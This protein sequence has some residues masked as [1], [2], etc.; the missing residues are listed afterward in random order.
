[1]HPDTKRFWGINV[2]I[3]LQFLP[4]PWIGTLP[5]EKLHVFSQL[6]AFNVYSCPSFGRNS[7]GNS[8]LSCYNSCCE[9]CG[10]K[11]WDS[12]Y[13]Q[14]K[15]RRLC[16]VFKFT[17]CCVRLISCLGQTYLWDWCE[18]GATALEKTECSRSSRDFSE[19][20]CRNHWLEWRLTAPQCASRR[21]DCMWKKGVSLA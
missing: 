6:S 5:S 7:S 20:H 17:G 11:L 13:F 4:L 15:A 8:N 19:T 21:F 9:V 10:S 2:N 3:T 12:L 14:L 16:C 1:M 18:Q